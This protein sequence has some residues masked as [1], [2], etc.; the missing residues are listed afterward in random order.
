LVPLEVD[1]DGDIATRQLG[2]LGY[3][4]PEFGEVRV[5]PNCLLN[6]AVNFPVGVARSNQKLSS[7]SPGMESWQPKKFSAVFL[8]DFLTYSSILDHLLGII[9]FETRKLHNRHWYPP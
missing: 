2:G 1:A 9:A 8:K 7:P 6:L 5:L 4:R 3:L